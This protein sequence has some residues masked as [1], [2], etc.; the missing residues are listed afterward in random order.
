[1]KQE[2][3]LEIVA[4]SNEAL[5]VKFMVCDLVWNDYGELPVQFGNLC[6]SREAFLYTGKRHRRCF[7]A[8]IVSLAGGKRL[9]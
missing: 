8:V 4:R 3:I 6:C 7:C 1:M 5:Q 2:L 9:H